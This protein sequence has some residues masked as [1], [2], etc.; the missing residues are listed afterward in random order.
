MNKGI[1]KKVVKRGLL[2]YLFLVLAMLIIFY[3][4]SVGNQNVE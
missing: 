4:V 2:P 3:F 1:D